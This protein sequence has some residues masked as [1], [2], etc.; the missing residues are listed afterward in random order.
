MP[1]RQSNQRAG[2]GERGRGGRHLAADAVQLSGAVGVADERAGA[3]E[4]EAAGVAGGARPRLVDRRRSAHVPEAPIGEQPG[5]GEDRG[6]VGARRWWRGRERL[7]GTRGGARRV[8]GGDAIV[9]AEADRFAARLR[10]FI[11]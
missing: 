4:R 8:R 1:P 11:H 2:G 9:V 10:A 7:V 5:G 6:A 3:A